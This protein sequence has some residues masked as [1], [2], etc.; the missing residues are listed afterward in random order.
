MEIAII[1]MHFLLDFVFQADRIA[2]NKSK[3]SNVLFEHVGIYG[4]GMMI[5]GLKFGVI[6]AGAHFL[7]DYITSRWCARLWAEK[8]RHRFF[9]VIGLDQAIHMTTLIGTYWWLS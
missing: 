7:T 6:N 4:V 8:K 3:N 5:F 1:W 2:L 9:V